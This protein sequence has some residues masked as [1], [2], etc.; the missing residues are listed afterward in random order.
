M[1]ASPDKRGG[2]KHQDSGGESA[3]KR[4]VSENREPF[5]A[6]APRKPS[7]E[8]VAMLAFLLWEKRGS[9]G[10]DIEDWLKAEKM[11]K[12]KYQRAADAQDSK[13]GHEQ[14]GNT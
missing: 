12:E 7:F 4:E 9:E 2:G 8:E 14:D 1:N 13:Q 10:D 3:R 5:V 6:S 11:L